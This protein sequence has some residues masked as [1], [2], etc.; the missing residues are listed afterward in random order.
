MISSGVLLLALG[1][2]AISF[3]NNLVPFSLSNLL[4]GIGASFAFI[5]VGVVISQWFQSKLFPILFGR[6]LF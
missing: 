3:A 1:N 6:A 2:I 5:A 4:Q